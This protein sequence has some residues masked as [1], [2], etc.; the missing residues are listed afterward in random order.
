MIVDYDPGFTR[1]D[2]AWTAT[3]VIGEIMYE[4][5]ETDGLGLNPKVEMRGHSFE[6]T[7][8][9]SR[10]PSQRAPSTA[11]PSNASARPA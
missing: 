3:G 2:D 4:R 6:V 11:S 10:S 5:T 9:D 7:G 8:V 1:V